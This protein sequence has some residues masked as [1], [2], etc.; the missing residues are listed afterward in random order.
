M[1]QVTAEWYVVLPCDMPL[2]N[3]KVMN[4]L[5]AEADRSFD[6]VIPSIAGRQQPLAAVYHRRVLP[7]ITAQL[8]KGNYRM[9]DLLSEV[10]VKKITE[11]DLQSTERLFQNI[12]TKDAYR[13]L[14]VDE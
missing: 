13:Q 8:T 3:E 4:A 2:I 5:I 10:N 7:V 12:N 9:I 11:A 14:F 6:A 1:K